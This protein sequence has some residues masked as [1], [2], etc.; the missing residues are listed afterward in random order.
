MLIIYVVYI[1]D[2][3]IQ[4]LQSLFLKASFVCF[5]CFAWKIT[6]DDHHYNLA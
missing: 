5:C 2:Y 6:I 1:Y 3:D 4:L